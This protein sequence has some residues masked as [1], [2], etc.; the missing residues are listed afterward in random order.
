MSISTTSDFPPSLGFKCFYSPLFGENQV[1]AFYSEKTLYLGRWAW[2]SM[3]LSFADSSDFDKVVQS[4]CDTAIN[5]LNQYI[6]R[7]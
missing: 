1:I 5:Y 4:C 3:T 2:Y 6:D 7:L